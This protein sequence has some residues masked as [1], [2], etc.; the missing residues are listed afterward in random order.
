MRISKEELKRLRCLSNNVLIRVES[1]AN[2][3]I[4]LKNG[5][6][7]YLDSSFNPDN[8][9]NVIGTIISQTD[10]IIFDKSTPQRSM[11]WKT[12]V[13]TKVGDVVYMDY[14]AIAQAYGKYLHTK[15]DTVNTEQVV[16]CDGEIY[17]FLNYGHLIFTK[18]G[19]EIK[20]LNGYVLCEPVQECALK[21]KLLLEIPDYIKTKQS[22]LYGKVVCKGSLN[23]DY[24]EDEYGGDNFDVEAG[25]V[26]VFDKFND[27][28]VEY[29]IFQ[30]LNKKYFRIQRRYIQAII[31][32]TLYKKL[33][34]INDKPQI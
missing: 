24:F 12:E 26:I 15:D 34:I 6:K 27:I 23:E 19:D 32:K 8:N 1:I 31:P 33:G 30:K 20:M 7:L 10:K 25:D 22:T 14:C 17:V 13:E 3:S 9:M 28:E 4:K 29:D 21:D 11:G 5:T 2:D 16:F 18:R